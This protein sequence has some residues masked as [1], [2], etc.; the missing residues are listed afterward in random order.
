MGHL[1]LTAHIL[2]SAQ[3]GLGIGGHPD[4]T[5]GILL[6]NFSLPLKMQTNLEV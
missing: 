4:D 1:H 3:K 5:Y 6:M 2:D